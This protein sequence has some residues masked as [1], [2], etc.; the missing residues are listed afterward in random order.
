MAKSQK[1]LGLDQEVIEAIENEAK[2]L[3]RSVSWVVNMRL[4]EIYKLETE[5][6]KK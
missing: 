3:N 6:G 5:E 4:R 1:S 2:E